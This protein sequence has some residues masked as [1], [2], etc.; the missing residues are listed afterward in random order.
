M[1]LFMALIAL[2]LLMSFTVVTLTVVGR[3]GAEHSASYE[4]MRCLYIAEA[5]LELANIELS[6]GESGNLGSEAAPVSI[7]YG[8]FWVVATE[9]ENDTVTLRCEA[10]VNGV[11]R[12]VSGIAA[13]NIAVFHHAIF[14]GNS[15]GDPNYSLK[16]GGSGAQADEISGDIYSGQDIDVTGQVVITGEVTVKG[17]ATGVDA[18]TSLGQPLPDFGS[19]NYAVN[20]DVDVAAEFDSHGVSESDEAGGIALQLPQTNAAHVFRKNPSDRTSATDPTEK[21]DYF[22]EDPYEEAT[23]DPDWDGSDAYIVSLD[24]G[25]GA[26]RQNK[27]YYIDGNLWIHSHPTYSYKLASVPEGSQITFAVKGNIYIGDNFFYSD[28]GLDG[29]AFVALVDDQVSDSGNIYFGDP[30]AGT[31]ETMHGFMYAENNF[32]ENNLSSSGSDDVRL[33]G[34]MAAGNQIEIDRDANAEFH[35]KL[36]VEFDPKL[37]DGSVQI[38]GAPSHGMYTLGYSIVAWFRDSVNE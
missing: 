10:R 15:S 2:F 34:T 16:F 26:T 18:K 38:P 28:S 33:F 27:T 30:S 17:I 20:H 14:A 31:L 3:H 9:N 23:L 21:D 1:A 11:V 22:L 8:E 5:G 7:E 6:K 24:T 25:D 13:P 37:K 12:I 35:N 32:H 4:N 29:V 19:M 36:V